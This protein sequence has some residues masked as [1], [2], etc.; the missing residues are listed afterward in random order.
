MFCD[1]VWPGYKMEEAEKPLLVPTFKLKKDVPIGC[2]AW[3]PEMALSFSKEYDVKE[4]PSI[5]LIRTSVRGGHLITFIC[6]ETMRSTLAS[7]VVMRTV[8]APTYFP[9]YQG[10]IGIVPP[11]IVVCVRALLERGR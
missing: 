9:T 4:S 5:I 1:T 6:S 7:D 8:A 10:Y 2:T 3:S 11:L